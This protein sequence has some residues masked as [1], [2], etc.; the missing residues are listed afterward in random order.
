MAAEIAWIHTAAT[1]G[2]VVLV[3]LRPVVV[4]VEVL[5]VLCLLRSQSMCAAVAMAVALDAVQADRQEAPDPHPC[6]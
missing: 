2:V 5:L 1:M 4:V 6:Q 3:I